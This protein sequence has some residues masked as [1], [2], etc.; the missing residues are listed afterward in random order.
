MS[1]R[2]NVWNFLGALAFVATFFA[3]FILPSIPAEE[4]ELPPRDTLVPLRGVVESVDYRPCAYSSPRH[5]RRSGRCYGATG[6]QIAS[7][8]RSVRMHVFTLKPSRL[9]KLADRS[10]IGKPVQALVSGPCYPSQERCAYEVVV[11]GATLV[12]YADYKKV[13]D[14][15][16]RAYI[17][18]A[19]VI[20]LILACSAAL[21][22]GL[23]D[24]HEPA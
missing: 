6:F 20:G 24:V 13:E 16:R 18:L 1:V 12:T 4:S 19:I 11:G 3:V 15:K 22:G 7:E 14:V 17:A 5:G 8:D 9:R 23:E 21:N 10:L 2:F